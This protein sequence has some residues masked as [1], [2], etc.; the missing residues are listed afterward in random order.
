MSDKD[1]IHAGHRS[2]MMNKL[3]QSPQTLADHELLEILLFY[4]L[5]RID[6]NGL[7]HRLIKVFGGLDG[8]INATPDALKAVEG[9]GDY[10]AGI[11]SIMSEFTKRFSQ[12]KSQN[13]VLSTPQKIRQEITEHFDKVEYET[14]LL[15]MLDERYKL[16][17]KTE[18]SIGEYKKVS[19]EISTISKSLSI[20][21]PAFVVIAH[22]HT[23][24]E[25]FAS[26][27]DDDATRKINLLCEIHGCNLIDH[28]IVS[29]NG[30]YYSYHMSGRLDE[31]RK[32]T[33]VNALFDK[34][35]ENNNE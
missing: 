28:V 30:K 31:I 4:A 14:F 35:K 17:M 3:L 19:A 13:P 33:E 6:T 26:N 22:N 8:V 5:P 12:N 2:R 32:Q 7:A 18:F 10:S 23:S 20:H 24:G 27:A 11:I 9:V 21:K 25:V 15:I 16:I 34:I 29:K 1:N